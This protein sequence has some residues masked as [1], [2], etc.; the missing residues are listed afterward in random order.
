[1][2]VALNLT[3]STIILGVDRWS[4]HLSLK[5]RAK[6]DKK[7]RPTTCCLEEF[8]ENRRKNCLL[9]MPVLHYRYFSLCLFLSSLFVCLFFI[10]GMFYFVAIVVCI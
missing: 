9:I 7:G 5:R 2:L 1:M 8:L 10:M 4:K 6:L 3:M